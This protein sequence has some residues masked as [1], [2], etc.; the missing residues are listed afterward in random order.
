MISLNNTV[1]YKTYD[2]LSYEALFRRLKEPYRN[3]QRII[4]EYRKHK[5]GYDGERNVD[6]KLSTFP[7]N[8]FFSL[9]GL[10]LSN[11]PHYFQMDTLLLT[12]KLIYLL[13]IKNLQGTLHYDSKLCQMTQ[14]T[15]DETVA[16]KDPILQAEAQKEH[17][18]E[19]LGD[20]GIFDVPIET[21]VVVAYPTTIIN[22]IHQE[23]WVYNKLIHNEN[24][25][26]H[27]HRLSNLYSKDIMTHSMIQKLGRK[28]LQSNRPLQNDIPAKHGLHQNHF[29]KGIPCSQCISSPMIRKNRKWICPKCLHESRDAHI[30][31]IL[32][33]FLLFG[34]T[35]TNRQCR[36]L[37]GLNSARSAYLILNSMKLKSSGK[38]RGK[39]YH[40]PKLG[41]FPQKSYFPFL[42]RQF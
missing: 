25:H 17:L 20:L 9:K 1:R 40:A 6:Y 41:D 38:N 4:S 8:D 27:L 23:Q 34:K 19:F 26:H 3:D 18:Q 16:H 37:L 29:I 28:L 5:A 35:I 32:D 31:V 30:Q 39:L 12:R 10:R 13:E 2:L 24:L 22:N 15:K 14:E 42:Y 33:H 7:Q 11:H 36:E 21:L